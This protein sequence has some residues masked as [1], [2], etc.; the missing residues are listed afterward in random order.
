M[1]LTI[2]N[3]NPEP[4]T[5]EQDIVCYKV[6]KKLP[7]CEIL[8]API[9]NFEYCFGMIYSTHE[10]YFSDIDVCDDGECLVEYGFH[11]FASLSDAV[12]FKW[13]L[14]ETTRHSFEFV[15]VE[16]TIPNASRFYIG[17]QNF[18][19]HEDNSPDGYC[20]EAIRI[21]RIVNENEY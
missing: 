19:L 15:V 5:T 10:D 13:R 1:C 11:S 2:N 6:L 17:K 18:A 16:C 4:M 20:S 3:N 21:E 7:N 12:R 9:Y 8:S 14:L